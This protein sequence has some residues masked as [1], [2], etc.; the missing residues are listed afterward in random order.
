[1]KEGLIALQ[2]VDPAELAPGEFAHT[3]IRSV[4]HKKAR[5]V[6]IDSLNG[7]LNAMPEER[8]LTI[9]MH[10]LL[11]YLNQQGVITILV[12]AQHGFLGS[13]MT[14]PVDVSYLADTVLML[15][16]F[17]AEGA[18]HRALS[19]VKR[20]SGAHE[21]TIRELEITSEGI[22]VG[23]PLTKFQ[24]I[25]TGVPTYSGAYGALI[26]EFDGDA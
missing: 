6:I 26:K 5:V 9:Q 16:Y 10:E 21:N 13:S 4:A 8:F 14:S 3:V 15:R 24:G 1:M 12:M 20:R 19:V 11:M 18:V 7:Y 17:E 25:L 22:R 2:Q 23:A